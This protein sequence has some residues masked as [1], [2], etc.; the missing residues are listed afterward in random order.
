MKR[1]FGSNIIIEFKIITMNEI[2]KNRLI[3]DLNKKGINARTKEKRK[4]SYFIE[5]LR[6]NGLNEIDFEKMNIKVL[7]YDIE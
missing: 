3:E 2:I 1:L 6:E 5:M 4:D 7:S